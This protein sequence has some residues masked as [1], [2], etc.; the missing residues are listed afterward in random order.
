MPKE[1]F[2][3][4]NIKQTYNTGTGSIKDFKTLSGLKTSYGTNMEL[5]FGDLIGGSGAGHSY[6]SSSYSSSSSGG[7]GYSSSSGGSGGYGSSIGGG[8]SYGSLGSGPFLNNEIFGTS[9]S[10]SGGSTQSCQQR[11]KLVMNA[12]LRCASQT[13]TCQ[14]T[15][16]PDYVF[17]NGQTSVFLNCVN[18]KWIIKNSAWTE[19]PSCERNINIF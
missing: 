6:K 5:G 18:N 10:I 8:G 16:S 17:P 12:S 14:I 3:K 4:F 13:Q 7:G 15:C 2:E 1:I 19:I 9:S 11:P